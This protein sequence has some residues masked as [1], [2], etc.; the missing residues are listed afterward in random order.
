M[1]WEKFDEGWAM[2]VKSWCADCEEGAVKQAANL[3]Q[4]PALFHHVAL[5]PDAHRTRLFRR[6]SE[7][8]SAAE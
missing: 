8:T 2:P 3:A 6:R 1:K 4:H 7:W 5:M